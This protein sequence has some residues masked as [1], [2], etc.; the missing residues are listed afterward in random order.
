MQ[1][2]NARRRTQK[3][4]WF[5]SHFNLEIKTNA[6]KIFLQ[7]INTRF[8]PEKKLHKIFNRNPVQVNYSRTQNISQIIKGYNKKV[9]QIK[10]H[11]QLKWNCCIKTKCP[12]N[13]DCRKEDVIYKCTALATFQPNKVYLHLAEGEFKKQSYYNHTQ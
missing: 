9:T 13:D 6:E 10:R 2:N 8:P 1:R 12:L 4:K 3:D 5:D 11:H 7:L